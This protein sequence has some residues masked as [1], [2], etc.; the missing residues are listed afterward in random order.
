MGT[1]RQRKS[2][3]QGGKALALSLPLQ[4]PHVSAGVPQILKGCAT[5]NICHLQVNMTLGPEASGFH[6]ISKPECD[7][8]A[9]PTP[10][11]ALNPDFLRFY[12]LCPSQIPHA[13]PNPMHFQGIPSPYQ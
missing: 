3:N 2:E 4:L 1:F 9:T 8:V 11:G 5:P 7:Y 13:L 6:L 10:S 12:L